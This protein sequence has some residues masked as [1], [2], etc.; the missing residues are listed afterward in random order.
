MACQMVSNYHYFSIQSYFL[1]QR[2]SRYAPESISCGIFSHASDV[3]SYGVTLWET[4]TFGDQPYDNLSGAEVFK[5]PRQFLRNI[6]L[7]L[8]LI[9]VA[10]YGIGG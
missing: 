9:N 2:F 6:C 7:K 10:G 3:W 4:Y 8:K 5:F 1:I